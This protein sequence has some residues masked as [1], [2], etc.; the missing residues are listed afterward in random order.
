MPIK[1]LAKELVSQIAAGE[2][3]ERPA[4]VVKELVENSLDA[5]SSQISIEVKGGGAS[6][7]RVTDNGSGIPTVEVALAFRRHATSKI[8]SISDLNS[9]LSLGFRGEALPSIAAVAQVDIVTSAAGEPAG[10]Y[11]AIRDGV[12][13]SQ[14]SQGRSRGATVTVRNLFRSLPAR[15]KFLKSRSTENSHIANVVSQYALAFPEVKF[16]LSIDGR[17]VLRTPG[18]GHLIDSVL[19]VHGLEVARNMLEVGGDRQ[20]TGGVAGSSPGVTGMVSS[21]EVSRSSRRHLSFF[22]NRRWVSSRMLAWAVEEAYHG[23]LMTGKHPVA[24]INL[25]LPP[26]EVDINIHPR[27]SEVKFRDESAVFAAVQKAARQALVKLTPVPKIEAVATAYRET[28]KRRPP[29]PVS[30]VSHPTAQLPLGPE[31]P[32]ASLPVL[33]V[34]GQLLASYIIAEGPDGLY[35]IDQHAAHERILF[36]KIKKQKLQP[37]IEVQGL[38]EP[39]VFEVSP[40]QEEVLKAYYEDLAQFGFSI[41][42]FGARTY[43]VRTVPALL[44]EKDWQGMVTEL[45]D[46]PSGDKA[47]FSEKLTVSMACHSAVRAGQKLSGD[48]MRELLRQL[49]QVSLPNTCPHGRPTMV[50]ITSEELKR[51]FRRV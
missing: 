45:L 49:E 36:E 43:L 18:S 2:V 16:T 37:E 24:I 9:I 27:K 39:A 41:E 15:L 42:P 50:H 25:T 44:Y 22:V 31:T 30:A 12:V 29:L 7:I 48:E 11:L 6:L 35:L 13:T 23:L 38:L 10:S 51:E 21:P 40:Q 1:V 28:S 47:D 34:L 46:L 3:V 17:T 5:G 26:E 33:R 19:Q 32:A 20:W 14:A 4:S 8:G